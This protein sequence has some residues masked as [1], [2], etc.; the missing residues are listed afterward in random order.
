M[1]ATYMDDRYTPS[2]ISILFVLFMI[3]GA[4]SSWAQD[5]ANAE[6]IQRART[7]AQSLQ[8]AFPGYAVAVSDGV[9]I[10]WQE[11]F[12]LADLE[13]QVAVTPATRFPA[14][15]IAKKWTAAGAARL[16]EA[17]RLNPHESIRTYLPGYPE[18]G[19]AITPWQLA[20]HTSGIRHYD[21]DEEVY[22]H[23]DCST[24]MDAV[25][26]FADD[27]LL[28]EPGAKQSYSTWGYVLLS[29]VMEAAAEE[30]FLSYMEN[31]VFQPLG[32]RATVFGDPVQ[33]IPDRSERFEH[34]EDGSYRNLYGATLT[35]KWGGG[36][37]LTTAG[38]VVRFMTGLRGGQLIGEQLRDQILDPDDQGIV[39][40]GGVSP[41]GQA[42]VWMDVRTGRTVAILA[43]ARNETADL[44]QKAEELA[45]A[46]W[47]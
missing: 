43:N 41:G 42:A 14:F 20:T 46:F 1:L 21:G 32:M 28:F 4:H 10:V 6:P 8:H 9:T 5:I 24:V 11:G 13:H 36:A 30:D 3:S 7:V 38:D 47:R 16:V 29:A 19:A 26:I 31:H 23:R 12:G 22:S 39:R 18:E 33:I 45:A 40:T 44:H 37:F 25:S 17:G 27:P 15:S 2:R 34:A 35:C